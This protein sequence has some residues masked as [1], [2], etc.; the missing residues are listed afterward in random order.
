MNLDFN[1]QSLL[2]SYKRIQLEAIIIV[3]VTI[4]ATSCILIISWNIYKKRTATTF[5]HTGGV[6]VQIHEKNE[7]TIIP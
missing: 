3:T 2:E 4:L 6:T 7:R 1:R 5:L